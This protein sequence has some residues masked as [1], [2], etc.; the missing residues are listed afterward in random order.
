[1]TGRWP[2]ISRFLGGLFIASSSALALAISSLAVL[3]V[4]G[5]APQW[6][7]II[8]SPLAALLAATYSLLGLEIYRHGL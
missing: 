8:L 6:E 1:M 3:S 4:L 2:R 5:G 7:L